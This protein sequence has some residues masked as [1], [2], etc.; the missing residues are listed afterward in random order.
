MSG[1]ETLYDAELRH[2]DQRVGE[3]LEDALLGLSSK[4]R[5]ILILAE[6]EGC[7]YPFQPNVRKKQ[8]T[9]PEAT[10]DDQRSDLDRLK[11]ASTD[12]Y[13]EVQK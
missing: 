9:V 10:V 8:V 6:G 11:A 13:R 2:L 5:A 3:L 12:R 4:D 1:L 7:R